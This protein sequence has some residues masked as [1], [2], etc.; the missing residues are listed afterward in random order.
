VPVQGNLDMLLFNMAII[1]APPND[2]EPLIHA[3]L[4]NTLPPKDPP[5]GLLYKLQ[6]KVIVTHLNNKKFRC[7]QERVVNEMSLN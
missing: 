6:V 1:F 7:L 3:S 4:P 2:H 5:K